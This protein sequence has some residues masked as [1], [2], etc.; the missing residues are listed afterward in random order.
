MPTAFW[1]LRL[2]KS[3]PY[4]TYF[5]AP[6]NVSIGARPSPVAKGA[7]RRSADSN[8]GHAFFAEYVNAPCTESDGRGRPDI[9]WRAS[10]CRRSCEP[11]EKF[12][13]PDCGLHPQANV[14]EQDTVVQ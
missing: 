10:T 14:G 13:T 2:L 5:A 1:G 8:N 12:Q 6:A 7:D 3:L 11:S 9:R 4:R